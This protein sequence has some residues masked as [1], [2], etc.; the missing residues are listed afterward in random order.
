MRF[1]RSFQV[2]RRSWIR[3]LTVFAVIWA[4][5]VLVTKRSF[6]NPVDYAM[7]QAPSLEYEQLRRRVL[8]NTKE[9]W[10]LVQGEIGKMRRSIVTHDDGDVQQLIEVDFDLMQRRVVELKRWLL[11]DMQLMRQVDGY[12]GFRQQEAK[13]L[14]E[15]VQHRLTALQHPTD[16]ATARKLVCR[17]EKNCGFGCT[18]HHL[19][20]CLHIAYATER[21]LILLSKG[22]SYHKAGW[23]DVFHPLSNSCTVAE[24]PTR[25]NF[26]FNHEKAQ[27][28]EFDALNN[29]MTFLSMAVPAD[30]AGRLKRL[31]GDPIVWWVGQVLKYVLR[32][33]PDT[34]AMLRDRMEKLD[35]R[36]PIVGVHIRRTDK[37]LAEAAMHTVDEYMRCVDD[38][39]RQLEMVQTVDK[40]RVFLATD[41]PL[42]IEEARRNYPHFHFIFDPDVARMAINRSLESSLNGILT[43]VHM[44]AMSDHL[45]CTLSSNVCR[46]AYEMMQA[47]HLDATN[48]LRSLDDSYFFAGDGLD[49]MLEAALAHKPYM[50]VGD[51]LRI[52]NHNLDG[53]VW[54][55]NLRTMERGVFPAFKLITKVETADYPKYGL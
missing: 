42:V 21:T 43:D 49:Q 1:A 35:F 14:S 50:D 29:K 30:L 39:Y 37:L 23:E 17:L 55:K 33:Q 5:F 3:R 41:E 4:I 24:L 19:V 54:G 11:N 47:M 40:R 31:H 32:L 2:L 10:M 26:Y 51:V 20:Y 7:S 38:Y 8:L 36:Q 16:C 9:M 28:I 44:L 22:W 15:L 48:R 18:I 12:D 13:S 6:R 46:L 34:E 45:I 52:F 25:V 53:F 27:V